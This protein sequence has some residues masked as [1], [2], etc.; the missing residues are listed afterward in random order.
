MYPVYI[1]MIGCDYDYDEVVGV[2][3]DPDKA[4]KMWKEESRGDRVYVQK[5]INETEYELFNDSNRY[6]RIEEF[7]RNG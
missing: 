2:T 1:V 3:F 5:W 4:I 6:P 7:H